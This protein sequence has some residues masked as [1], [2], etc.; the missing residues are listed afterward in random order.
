LLV[1]VL[2]VGLVGVVGILISDNASSDD[3]SDSG[4]ET[5]VLGVVLLLIS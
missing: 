3:D 2:A 1:I 5:S 4:T